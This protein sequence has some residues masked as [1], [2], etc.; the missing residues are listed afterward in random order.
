MATMN[1]CD[2]PPALYEKN[3]TANVSPIPIL[4]YHQIS[5]APKKGAPFRVL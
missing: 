1:E 5:D 3:V 4:V 2:L